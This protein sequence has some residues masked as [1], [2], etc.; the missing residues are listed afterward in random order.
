VKLSWSM[1]FQVVAMIAQYGNQASGVIP[2]KYQSGV[3]L[4]VGLAQT[5]V[6]WHQAHS[7]PDGT[8]AATPYVKK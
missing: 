5:V 4:I 8:P 1:A 3:M 7:N 2:P 6:L